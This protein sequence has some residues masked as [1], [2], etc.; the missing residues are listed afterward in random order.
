MET[1]RKSSKY[2]QVLVSMGQSEIILEK[3]KIN[4]TKYFMNNSIEK[5]DDLKQTNHKKRKL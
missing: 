5:F 4:S 1:Q 2:S 3:L